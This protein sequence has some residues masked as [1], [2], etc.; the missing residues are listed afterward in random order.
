M[1]DILATVFALAFA[2]FILWAIRD[3][4]RQGK[5]PEAYHDAVYPFLPYRIIRKIPLVGSLFALLYKEVPL[6]RKGGN[7]EGNDNDARKS[8]T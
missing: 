7:Q 2:L 6:T 8:G 3:I 4:R 5:Y 1:G